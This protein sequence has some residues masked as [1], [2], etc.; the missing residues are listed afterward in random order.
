MVCNVF[1]FDFSKNDKNLFFISIIKDPKNFL[2]HGMY[3]LIQANLG[4][5]QS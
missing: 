2:D 1:A 5:V 3:M 4:Y